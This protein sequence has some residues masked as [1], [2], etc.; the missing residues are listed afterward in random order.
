MI[1]YATDTQAPRH[2]CEMMSGNSICYDL[3]NPAAFGVHTAISNGR[4]VWITWDSRSDAPLPRHLP[5]SV[6][7]RTTLTAPCYYVRQLTD[8][9]LEVLAARDAWSRKWK[10]R[11]N[12][13]YPKF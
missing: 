9:E 4:L 8:H 6:V 1:C 12:P 13:P 3:S 7:N 5:V 2:A 11:N 10:P